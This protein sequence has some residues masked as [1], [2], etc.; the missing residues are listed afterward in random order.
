[1]PLD[2]P[3]F[4]AKKN[5]LEGQTF[6]L[7]VEIEYTA[8]QFVRWV[9]DP[10]YAPQ[11]QFGRTSNVATVSFEGNLY[12][13]FA[14]GRP[15]RSQ[16]SRGEIPMFDLPIANPKRVF[17]STIQTY[18]LEGKTGRLITVDRDNL[19]DPTAKAEE[20][21]TIEKAESTGEIITLT[22]KGVRFNPLRSRIPRKNMTRGNYPGLMG[23]TRHRFY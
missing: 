1:M 21:F 11:P 15:T 5:A 16:N 13:P 18:I 14:I 19:S 2:I 20:W 17:Q 3:A 8:G 9:C 23:S 7:L 6:L 12:V 10:E 22:C 4:I